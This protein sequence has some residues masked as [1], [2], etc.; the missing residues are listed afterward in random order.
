M[1]YDLLIP[2]VLMLSLVIFGNYGIHLY[3]KYKRKLLFSRIGNQNFAEAKNIRTEIYAQSK[4]SASWQFFRSDIILFENKLLILLRNGLINMNQ[5]IIQ[6][7]KNEKAE[8]LDGVTK[9]YVLQ[10][11]EYFETKI[12][13][14]ST[15]VLLVK[16]DFEINLDFKDKLEELKIVQEFINDKLE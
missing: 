16:A 3:Y 5:P 9:I 4:L 15:Q 6:I 7:S 12:K 11:K 13:I 10:K 1:N 8:K 14:N 2:I